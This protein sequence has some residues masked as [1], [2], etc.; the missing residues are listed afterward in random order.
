M[1]IAFEAFIL[2]FPSSDLCAKCHKITETHV[3]TVQRSIFAMH[4][5]AFFCLITDWH[6]FF[7]K[8]IPFYHNFF[9][10]A[11]VFP[12]HLHR[13]ASSF[14]CSFLR[15]FMRCKAPVLGRLLFF[16][17]HSQHFQQCDCWKLF[18]YSIC[19]PCFF[20]HEH[21]GYFGRKIFIFSDNQRLS[22]GFRHLNKIPVC[23]L[24]FRNINVYLIMDRPWND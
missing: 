24:F 23:C 3:D 22:A 17:I 7:L 16:P 20:L 1:I 10:S 2:H 5:Y 15:I 4:I 19:I 14:F 18:I 6:R 9:A 13:T 21:T 8:N 11:K 12:F